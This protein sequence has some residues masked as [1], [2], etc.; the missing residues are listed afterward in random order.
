MH[1]STVS[2]GTMAEMPPGYCVDRLAAVAAKR[3]MAVSSSSVSASGAAQLQQAAD[4]AAAEDIAC[5]RR[6][7]RQDA[8]RGYADGCPGILQQAA[9]RPAGD[10]GQADAEVRKQ[11]RCALLGAAAPEKAHLVVADLDDIGLPQA[12]EDLRLRRIGIRPQRQAEVRVEAEE[13]AVRGGVGGG[14]LRGGAHR[15]LRQAQAAEVEQTRLIQQRKIQ[16][17]KAELRVRARLAGKAERALAAG[18]E[19]D[20]GQ[21]CEHGRIAHDALRADA[22]LRQRGAQQVA[23][24]IRADLA[25]HGAAAAVGVQGGQKIPGAPPGWAARVG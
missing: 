24:R 22:G 8:R 7:D 21:R 15:L 5:A 12:P 19:R 14:L 23:E 16:L 20:E 2:S 1:R 4:G 6:V 9:L 10:H 13:L 18:A 3:P 17:V 25:E 11:A